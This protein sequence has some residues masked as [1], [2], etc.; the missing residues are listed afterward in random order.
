MQQPH[1]QSAIVIGAGAA[2]LAAATALTDAG[3]T[4]LCLEARERP[5]G[6]LLSISTG[7]NDTLTGAGGALDLGA[8]WFWDGEERV[9]S[10]MGRL[11]LASFPQHAAGSALYQDANGTRRLP[12]NPLATFAHR[13]TA[14]AGALTD[15]LAAALPTGTL[16][17]DTAVTGIRRI[18]GGLAVYT[19]ETVHHASHVVLAVPPAV[20]VAR[21]D[22]GGELPPDLVTLARA[23]PV[24]MG[25]VIKVVAVYGEPFWRADGLA[26]TAVS[27]VGPLREVHDMS[28]PD[29]RPAALLGFAPAPATDTDF[30]QAVIDQLAQLFG[31]A[32]AH[33]DALHVQDWSAQRWTAPPGV[34]RLTDYSLFGDARYQRPALGGRLH[35]ASTET[36]VH[37]AGH[38]DGALA[39][40]DRAARAVLAAPAGPS[41]A[42]TTAETPTPSTHTR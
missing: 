31:P 39:S 7:T 12:D 40:G 33:P 16:R 35:W 4:T 22:F 24:W 23:T 11:G 15:R 1:E 26:G 41:P 3:H 42:F 21:I 2:G 32:A 18:G 19:A 25:A 34:D 10:L 9:I 20:A 29:G 30:R 14:G 38:L 27:W 17:L 8:T 5:G 28:G 6:R 13:H 36:A 37:H